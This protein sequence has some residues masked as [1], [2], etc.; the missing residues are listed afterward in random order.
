MEEPLVKGALTPAQMTALTEHIQ[1]VLNAQEILE[2]GTHRRER[3]EYDDDSNGYLNSKRHCHRDIKYTKVETLKLTS[4]IQQQSNWKVDMGNVFRP[5]TRVTIAAWL[6]LPANT[7]IE[8][9]ESCRTC[10]KETPEKDGHWEYFLNWTKVI[11]QDSADFDSAIHEQ[12]HSARQ[13]ASQTPVD[14]NAHLHLLMSL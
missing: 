3:H 9:V 8:I 7:W 1:P 11:I 10:I 2:K 13:H 5:V 6:L 14:F 12:W 4:T